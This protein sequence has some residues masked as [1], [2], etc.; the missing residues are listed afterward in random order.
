[1]YLEV[2]NINVN[3]SSRKV[4][5]YTLEILWERREI[6]PLFQN[7][8]NIAVISGGKLHTRVPQKVLYEVV[9]SFLASEKVKV[10]IHPP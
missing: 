9:K 8:F 4:L 6:A 5:Q 7:V 2:C 3:K 1:M 10:I